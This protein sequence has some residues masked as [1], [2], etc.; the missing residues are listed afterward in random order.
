MPKLRNRP[1]AQKFRRCTEKPVLLDM[2]NYT[3]D[4]ELPL[5]LRTSRLRFVKIVKLA[6]KEFSFLN[7]IMQIAGLGILHFAIIS[8]LTQRQLAH[9]M[10][11]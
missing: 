8:T 2:S 5:C 1:F 11:L 7:C 4:E 10:H 6:L 9:L 3:S